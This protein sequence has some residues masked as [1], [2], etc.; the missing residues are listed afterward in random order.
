LVTFGDGK[1]TGS[2]CSRASFDS[3]KEA[4]Y[5]EKPGVKNVEGEACDVVRQRVNAKPLIQFI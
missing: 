4:D 3:S 5:V 2:A 1:E